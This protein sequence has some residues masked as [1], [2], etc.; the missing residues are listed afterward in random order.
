MKK[1]TALR[2]NRITECDDA[3]KLYGKKSI[4]SAIAIG[5]WVL[6]SSIY[7]LRL[8]ND[9]NKLLSGIVLGLGACNVILN[10]F[11]LKDNIKK[12]KYYEKEKG[13]LH[14]QIDN[15]AQKVLKKGF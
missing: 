14:N 4:Y 8:I 1:E 10:S 9:D 12:K 3:I 15:E 13:K 7:A 5:C 2:I 11:N 6:S